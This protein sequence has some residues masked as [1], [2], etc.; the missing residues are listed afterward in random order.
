[1]AAA[2]AFLPL[3]VPGLPPVRYTGTV[4]FVQT[5]MEMAG[6]V[7]LAAWI[8][9][10]VRKRSAALIVAGLGVVFLAGGASMT[11]WARMRAPHATPDAAPPPPAPHAAAPLPSP[12]AAPEIAPEVPLEPDRVSRS[13]PAPADEG[14]DAEEIARRHEA[15]A[16]LRK[17]IAEGKNALEPPTAGGLLAEGDPNPVYENGELLG[18]ELQNLRPDG[19]YARLG[20]R[21]GD[22]VQ[23][24]NGVGLDASARLVEE[25]VRAPLVELQVERRD[26]T[27]AVIAVPREQIVQGL[28]ELDEVAR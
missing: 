14:P 3:P 19:F 5:C 2:A 21:E 27:Q 7:L 1:V 4:N 20:L 8:P 18:I 23:S 11:Y 28:L 13:D 26:G 22:L 17:L 6:A 24:I 9:R 10:S 15:A 25:F 16:R 12:A